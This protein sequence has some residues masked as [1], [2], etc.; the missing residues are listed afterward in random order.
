MLNELI[1]MPGVTLTITSDVTVRFCEGGK[2]VI[3][4]NGRLALY[5]ML[6]GMDCPGAT[7][8]GVKVYGSQPNQPQFPIG[9]T[10]AQ[11]RIS[12]YP[13]SVIENA[14]AGIQLYGPDPAYAGGQVSCNGPTVTDC[15]I[16]VR[17]APYQDIFPPRGQ[18]RP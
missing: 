14:E 8:Q 13:G 18:P 16:G 11:G 6:S 9:G 7:W 1:V 10:W 4:P 3:K 12:C 15:R 17:C 2:L 5:G